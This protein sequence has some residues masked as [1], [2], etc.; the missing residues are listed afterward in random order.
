MISRTIA[1]LT[2]TLLSCVISV[3]AQDPALPKQVTVLNHPL[4][5]KENAGDGKGAY[6]AEYIPAEESFEHWTFMFASHFSVGTQYDPKAAAIKMASDIKAKRQSGDALANAAVFEADDGKSVVV[7]FL[8]ADTDFLEHDVWRY[9]RTETGLAS[10][11]IARRVYRE[12]G[13]EDTETQFIKDIRSLRNQIFKE[14]VRTDLPVIKP[15]PG[16]VPAK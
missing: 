2:L 5:L 10:F 8:A 13:K 14:I 9:F 3:H 4:V 15:A 7:D 6:I 1:T 16:G 11:Q 12:P